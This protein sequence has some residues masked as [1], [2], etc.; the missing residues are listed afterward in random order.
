[1]PKYCVTHWNKP[2]SNENGPVTGRASDAPEN[3][4]C[5]RP[6]N[7]LQAGRSIID[8]YPS[9]IRWWVL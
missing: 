7:A 8:G 3:T 2:S 5:P 4:I 1:M 9:V 6:E